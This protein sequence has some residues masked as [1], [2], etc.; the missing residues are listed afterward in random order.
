LTRAELL[1]STRLQARPLR[2]ALVGAALAAGAIFAASTFHLAS[3]WL[4]WVRLH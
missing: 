2:V 3:P 4:D 1:P